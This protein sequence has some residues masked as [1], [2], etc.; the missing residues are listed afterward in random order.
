M[1]IALLYEFVGRVLVYVG[2]PMP[3]EQG[4]WDEHLRALAAH[5]AQ[6]PNMRSLVWTGGAHLPATQRK[7]LAEV[8]PKT[9]RT[10]VLTRNT[11]DRGIVT[12]LGWFISSIKAFSPSDEV[13]A[14]AYLELGPE[15]AA[16]AFEV[17][18]RLR[19][20]MAAGVR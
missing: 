6:H 13:G 8:M 4:E 9:A 20:Q 15:E 12:A 3:P 10:A 19:K 1:A 7:Q 11:V 18:Q 5:A 16:S 2:G 14:V 17:G